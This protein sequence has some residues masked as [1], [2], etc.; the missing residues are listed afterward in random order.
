MSIRPARLKRPA[1]APDRQCCRP[2]SADEARHAHPRAPPSRRPNAPAGSVKIACGQIAVRRSRIKIQ[3][4]RRLHRHLRAR[5]ISPVEHSDMRLL[6]EGEEDMI[7]LL[8]LL[9]AVFVQVAGGM[10]LHPDFLAVAARSES[11]R[12]CRRSRWSARAAAHRIGLLP[13][14]PAG[15]GR[16]GT[17]ASESAAANRKGGRR[18]IIGDLPQIRRR[19]E[20]G[21]RNVPGI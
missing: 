7:A 8:M 14:M 16:A 13:V 5:L 15:L 9:Q 10:H 18:K 3:M 4:C 1:R 19:I 6:L 21:S 17:V 2:T 12:R 20:R 11:P